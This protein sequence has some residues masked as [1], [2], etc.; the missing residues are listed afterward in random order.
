MIHFPVPPFP[1]YI[2]GGEGV[3][4]PGMKHFRRTFSVYDLIYV[5]CGTLY[6][7][8]DNKEYEVREGEY[9]L[10]TPG[11][12]HYGHRECQEKTE[13]LWL[14]FHAE[15][16]PAVHPDAEV[17]WSTIFRRDSTYTEAPQFILSFPIKGK[18]KNR[19]VITSGLD[20]LFTLNEIPSPENKLRQQLQFSDVLISL[21]KEVFSIPTAAEQVTQ[22]I[23]DYVHQHYNEHFSMKNLSQKLLFH[24]DYLTRCMQQT[25][26]ITPLQ[27]LNQYRMNMAKNLISSTTLRMSDI[28]GKCGMEDAAY[29]SKLFK[30][31]EGISPRDYRRMSNLF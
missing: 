29:F 28:A 16:A 23:I 26:G 3:F 27:Y 19:E 17:D 25:M 10:L 12:E 13:I 22:S 15:T 6:M 18:V 5:T 7:T 24:Q 8:E 1:T 9:I 14:H 2:T 31:L 21:Q 11:W 4:H 20:R 30:K